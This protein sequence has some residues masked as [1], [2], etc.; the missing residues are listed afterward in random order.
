[1][2]K[3]TFAAKEVYEQVKSL[4]YKIPHWQSERDNPINQFIP[5]DEQAFKPRP[6]PSKLIADQKRLMRYSSLQGKDRS[7]QLCVSAAVPAKRP[8]S[9]FSKLRETRGIASVKRVPDNFD[10]R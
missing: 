4:G 2:P 6:D 9:P 3:I 5:S 8:Q 7:L 1:M 10:I